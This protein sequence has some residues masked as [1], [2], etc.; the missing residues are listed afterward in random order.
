MLEEAI[1]DS[2]GKSGSTFLV[3]ALIVNVVATGV[4]TG[5]RVN[6][7]RL[8]CRNSRTGTGLF[9]HLSMALDR[10]Q[11]F[12]NRLIHSTPGRNRLTVHLYQWSNDNAGSAFSAVPRLEL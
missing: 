6:Q 3:R 7:I 12:Y 11:T 4:Q 8:L 1:Q 2:K 5:P 9:L 10:S